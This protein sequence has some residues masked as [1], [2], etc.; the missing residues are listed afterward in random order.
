MTKQEAFKS[1]P[2]NRIKQW[3]DSHRQ[4]LT[5]FKKIEYLYAAIALTFGIIFIVIIPPGWNPDEPQHYWRIQQLAHLDIVSDEFP[6]PP[7]ITYTG[8]VLPAN[9]VNFILS[10]KGYVAIQD[11]SLRMNFPMWRNPGVSKAEKNGG[12][13]TSVAFPGSARYSPVVY[14]PQAVGVWLANITGMT[15]LGGFLLAKLLGLFTQIICFMYAIRIIPKGKWIIFILGLLPSTIAQSTALGGDVMTTSMCIVF[16]AVVLSLSYSKEKID[17]RKIALILILTMLIGLVKP[18]YLPL[19]AILLLIPITRKPYR[20]MRFIGTMVPLVA[21]AALPGLVWLKLTSFIQDNFNYG[22]DVAAQSSYVIHQPMNF[23]SAFARTYLTDDQPK[24]YKTL[25]GNFV[26]DT[27]PLP[28]IFMFL[29][30][31]LLVLACFLSSPRE[32]TQITLTPL[33]K[34]ILLLTFGILITL[35]SYGLY[36][37]FTPLKATSILGLQGRYFI[38]FL[39]LLLLVFHNPLPQDKQLKVKIISLGIILSMLISTTVVLVQRIYT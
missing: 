22:V 30:V 11:Y 6:G 26:W 29:G 14:I 4:D 34:T 1:Q 12:A 20:N 5:R 16:T 31:V 15:L 21:I 38:P 13:P 35:I 7:G 36:V 32:K 18:A 37:Y 33:I 3:R 23:L 2:F 28:L 10:Y 24:I 19:I 17:K 39:P 27:A 8:G 25:F 9:D